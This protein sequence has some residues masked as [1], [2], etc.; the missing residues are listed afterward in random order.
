VEAM[1]C[2][3]PFDLMMA[4]LVFLLELSK[5]P[6]FAVDTTTFKFEYATAL[7]RCCGA[8][9]Q[10]ERRPRNGPETAWQSDPRSESEKVIHMDSQCPT[11][12]DMLPS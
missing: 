12:C 4:I 11:L 9:V 10:A 1:F 2:L 3:V 6:G 8:E 5:A 7:P